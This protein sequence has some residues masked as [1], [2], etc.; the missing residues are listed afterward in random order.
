M[1]IYKDPAIPADLHIVCGYFSSVVSEL[2][3]CK[4]RPEDPYGRQTNGL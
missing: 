2:N 3:S 4:E 1:Q